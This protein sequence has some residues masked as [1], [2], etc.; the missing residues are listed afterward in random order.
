MKSCSEGILSCAGIKYGWGWRINGEGKEV[1]RKV[2][3]NSSADWDW[4]GG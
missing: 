3:T 4:S 2:E 1:R